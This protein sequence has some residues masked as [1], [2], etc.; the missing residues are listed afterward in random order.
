VSAD[1]RSRICHRR[2]AAQLHRQL[3]TSFGDFSVASARDAAALVTAVLSAVAAGELTPAD[4]VEIGKLIDSFV[5]AFE[6]A[7]L[8]ERLDR[9]EK[10]NGQ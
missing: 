3:Q 8:A 2:R 9:L 4:A 6:T 5:K 10:M 1:H 7:E